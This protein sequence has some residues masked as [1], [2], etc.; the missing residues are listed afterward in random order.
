[1]MTQQEP[2]TGGPRLLW[3]SRRLR[4]SRPIAAP[5]LWARLLCCCLTWSFSTTLFFPEA[6]S[7]SSTDNHSHN[8]YRTLGVPRSASLAEIKRAF[9]QRSLE[10]HP[11]KSPG[12]PET[13][14]LTLKEAYDILRD[15]QRRSLYDRGVKTG[16][17][18]GPRGGSATSSSGG[19]GTTSRVGTARASSTTHKIGRLEQLLGLV[20]QNREKFVLVHVYH[21]QSRLASVGEDGDDHNDPASDWVLELTETSFFEVAHVSVFQAETALLEYLNIDRHPRLVLFKENLRSEPFDI[22][23]NAFEFGLVAEHVKYQ[24]LRL[25]K[26]NAY[27]SVVNLG[28]LNFGSIQEVVHLTAHELQNFDKVHF[29]NGSGC[30]RVLYLAQ[31]EDE[32]FEFYM[33][34]QNRNVKYPFACFFHVMPGAVA[35]DAFPGIGGLI[36]GDLQGKNHASSLDHVYEQTNAPYVIV[37][38]FTE[39]G[40]EVQ[41]FARLQAELDKRPHEKQMWLREAT[42]RAVSNGKFLVL[43]LVTGGQMAGEGSTGG[44]GPGKR[45][46]LAYQNVLDFCEQIGKEGATVACFWSRAHFGAADDAGAAATTGGPGGSDAGSWPEWLAERAAALV[47]DEASSGRSDDLIS[48]CPVLALFDGPTRFVGLF[49]DDHQPAGRRFCLDAAPSEREGS[50]EK[51]LRYWWLR[52]RGRKAV[53]DLAVPAF[54]RTKP[55]TELGNGPLPFVERFY[56]HVAQLVHYVRHDFVETQIG[57]RVNFVSAEFAR[58]LQRFLNTVADNYEALCAAFF[59]L[60]C[61]TLVFLMQWLLHGTGGG[62]ATAGGGS[63]HREAGGWR[64]DFCF[65]VELERDEVTKPWGMQM[66]TDSLSGNCLRLVRIAA[67]GCLDLEYKKHDA[68]VDDKRILNGE[69][70]P[71]PISSSLAPPFRP[72]IGDYIR[73]ANGERVPARIFDV[74]KQERKLRIVVHRPQVSCEETDRRNGTHNLNPAVLVDRVDFLPADRLQEIVGRCT[75]VLVAVAGR[76]GAVSSRSAAPTTTSSTAP[77]PERGPQSQVVPQMISG[78]R[79]LTCDVPPFCRKGDALTGCK[80]MDAGVVKVQ[81]NMMQVNYTRLVGVGD[82]CQVGLRIGPLVRDSLQTTWG[83]DIMGSTRTIRRVSRF[84]AAF[85][86]EVGDKICVV[87]TTNNQPGQTRGQE[88]HFISQ[89]SCWAQ[90]LHSF[91]QRLQIDEVVV[92]RW[93]NPN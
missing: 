73:S 31:S 46:L 36:S 65:A 86:F 48:G 71:A 41:D 61:T 23:D 58:L 17:A 64:V 6:Q 51:A 82:K 59:I 16:R 72:Q 26:Q 57:R 19:G 9:R 13:A 1:M 79:Y 83:I 20:E 52:H 93:V 29:P 43:F 53:R 7:Q 2:A 63:Q 77:P 92:L 47:G 37:D 32:N 49:E 11:D 10:L 14:F 27:S 60:T 21:G 40:V 22:T 91:K 66:V 76:T 54:G 15:P 25:L 33:L 39:Q 38:P 28:L 3:L 35:A 90:V 42:D 67:G 84:A 78:E 89:H 8:L 12:A 50:L 55:A 81:N 87:K 34:A 70:R 18:G 85:G 44:G 62:G 68:L 45:N 80:S 69:A 88:E 30:L 75:E 5:P 4:R 24:A 74:F 56:Q